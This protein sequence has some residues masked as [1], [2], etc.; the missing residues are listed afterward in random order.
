MRARGD[1]D[2][3]IDAGL[4][5]LK[6]MEALEGTNF[7]A[8]SIKRVQ[9]RCGGEAQGF[10]YDFCMRALRTL[11]VAGFAAQTERGWMAGPK[12][13]LFS[14]RFNDFCMLV[15]APQSSEIS[16]LSKQ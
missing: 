14:T 13:L 4:R 7:E 10:T 2:Y 3:A 9:E 1:K 12:L 6:V 8:V 11:K 15:A 16:E 5:L